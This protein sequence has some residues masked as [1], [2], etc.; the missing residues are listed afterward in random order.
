[1]KIN[2]QN[3]LILIIICLFFGLACGGGGTGNI[4]GVERGR[5]K[6]DFGFYV[7]GK[8]FYP[9]NDENL[10]KRINW[11]DTSPNPQVEILRC[12]GDATENYATTYIVRM[13]GDEA[14]MQKF[15]DGTGSVWTNAD[16]RWLLGKKIRFN[17]ETGEKFEVKGMPWVDDGSASAPVTYI[18]AVAPDMKTA[19]RKFKDIPSKKGEDNFIILQLIDLE[20]GNLEN[21]KVNITKYSWLNDWENPHDDFQPPPAPS[22]KFV[23]EKGTD[24]KDKIK[25]PE[26]L[27]KIEP[28]KKDSK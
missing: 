27:E 22:K 23:W 15:D 28:E 7:N 1:M 8:R 11:C 12:F 17:V 10:S 5:L 13:K 24:G 26:L 16:G 20:T 21:R 3:L 6:Y 2:L 9:K 4:S 18:L 19:V 14:E 25:V